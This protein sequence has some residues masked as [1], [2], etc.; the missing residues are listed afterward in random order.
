VN[1]EP[2]LARR[3]LVGGLGAPHDQ[4]AAA[5]IANAFAAADNGTGVSTLVHTWGALDEGAFERGRSV[6]PRGQCAPV[7]YTTGALLRT[8]EK[9][10]EEFGE[11]TAL[12]LLSVR[13]CGPCRYALFEPAWERALSRAGHPPPRVVAVEQSIDGLRELVGDEGMSTLLDA[14][15]VA[16][17][18]REVLH[19][20]RPRVEEV[21]ELEGAAAAAVLRIASAIESGTAPIEALAEESGFHRHLER[22]APT[23]LA[24][25]LILGDPWSM[26]VEGDGQLNLPR[27]LARAGAE[28]EIPPFAL[29][30][31]YVLWQMRGAPY[32]RSQAPTEARISLAQSLEAELRT[33]LAAA[34]RAAGLGGFELPDMDELTELA[35][36]HLTAGVRGGYGHVEVGLAV[37]A[38]RER[39]AHLAISVKSFG[40]MP[41][42]GVSD[43]IVPTALDG[44]IP[45]LSLEVSGDGEAARESR[46]MLRIASAVEAAA[47]DLADARGPLDPHEGRGAAFAG[48]AAAS[49]ALAGTFEAGPRTHACTLACHVYHA[50][51]RSLAMGSGAER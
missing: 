43:A 18:L 4:L 17:V 35:A 13:S 20:L 47:A 6:L 34:S 49:D 2:S 24:R 11:A 23:P 27:V 50:S 15:L 25:V 29:W 39:R 42:N 16:D 7:L 51:S 46:L 9:I 36:P 33:R 37:R 3:L 1:G 41:S 38:R 26:H 45:F 30:L 32:G 40:C 22:C 31:N 12:S 48:A 28:V 44:A 19:R 21:D 5:A 10:E 8:A 14:L